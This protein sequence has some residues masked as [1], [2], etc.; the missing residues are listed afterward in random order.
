MGKKGMSIRNQN[1][2][3][4]CV[5]KKGKGVKIAF[6]GLTGSTDI[7]DWGKSKAL[8]CERGATSYRPGGILQPWIKR[9]A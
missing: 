5:F 6:M 3:Y 7:P 9:I 2:G 1:R 8:F 4:F